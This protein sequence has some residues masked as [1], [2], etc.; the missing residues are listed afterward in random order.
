MRV[1]F[2]QERA[3]RSCARVALGHCLKRKG[4][5]GQSPRI[6]GFQR[7][8]RQRTRARRLSPFDFQA[9]DRRPGLFRFLQDQM[10]IRSP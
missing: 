6:A 4:T 5:L 3:S 10:M 2:H 8:K 1:E 7:K 9:F